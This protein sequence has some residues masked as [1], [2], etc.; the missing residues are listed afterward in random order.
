MSSITMNAIS[1][2]ASRHLGD[3]LQQDVPVAASFVHRFAQALEGDL[4]GLVEIAEQRRR[5]GFA[6]V[7]LQD[8]RG[9]DSALRGVLSSGRNAPRSAGAILS[10][11]KSAARWPNPPRSW[12]L[13]VSSCLVSA[14]TMRSAG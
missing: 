9:G 8:Q 13:G 1:S 3:I 12:L 10:G 4:V 6:E 11:G 7:T 14:A 2:P 5:H